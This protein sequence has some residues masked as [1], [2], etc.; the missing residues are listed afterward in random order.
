MAWK[1]ISTADIKP[2]FRWLA[3]IIYCPIVGYHPI[4]ECVLRC[5]KRRVCSACPQEA[6]KL[7]ASQILRAPAEFRGESRSA[8]K[9]PSTKSKRRAPKGK[10]AEKGAKDLQSTL[11]LQLAP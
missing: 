1:L 3:E 10:K 4:T 8:Q 5:S 7:T 9:T 11:P 6:R 2:E